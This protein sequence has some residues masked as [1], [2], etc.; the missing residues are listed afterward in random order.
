VSAAVLANRGISLG[1]PKS[2]PTM[3]EEQ[4][5]AIA[6][7]A[8]RGATVLESRHAYCRMVSKNPP[9]TQDCWAFSLDPSGL[10]STGGIPATYCLVIVDASSG[11]VLSRS[12]G[13]EGSDPSS[14]PRDPRLGPA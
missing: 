9:I 7:D 10:A 8:V 3:S 14:L 12:W 11:E 5:A 2:A 13:W 6:S 1:E 4:A